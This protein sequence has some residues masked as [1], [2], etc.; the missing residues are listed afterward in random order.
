MPDVYRALDD[1][2]RRTVLDLLA[3]RDEQTL[4]ELCGA[5]AMRHGVTMTRQAISQHLA[6]LE[7]AGLVRAERRGRTKVHSFDPA[8][9]AAIV[10]RWRIPHPTRAERTDP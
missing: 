6:V 9:L 7:E 10:E 2:T 5:L 8:P 4:F 3:E 1:E